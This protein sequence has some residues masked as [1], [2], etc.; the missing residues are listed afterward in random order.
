VKLWHAPARPLPVAVR[1]VAGE[2][3]PSYA[4]RLAAANDLT[5][6]AVLRALGHPRT[7]IGKHLLICDARINEH[8]AAR[9]EAYTGI[10]RERLAR[11]LPAMTRQMH[12]GDTLPPD[13]PT[14]CFIRAQ[15]RP[16]CRKCEL[17]ATG[18]DR[19]A[20]LALPGW[21]PLVCHRHRRWL[22]PADDT[23][24]HDLSAA[25]GILAAGRRL[26]GL[27][28]RSG[29]RR[30]AWREFRTAWNITRDWPG[31]ALQRMPVLAERWHDRAAALGTSTFVTT[32][33]GNRASWIV[34]FPEAVA[35][36][37]ILTDLNLR[38]YIALEY[39]DR[40]L[41]RRISASIGEQR[42]QAWA[43]HNAP[44]RK[45]VTIHRYKFEQLRIGAWRMPLPPPERF[46]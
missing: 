10:P 46:K 32:P 38:R 29:D 25:P 8:A 12:P 37:A 14:L 20:A 43:Y 3:L 23:T 5:P 28:A 26:A 44:V 4:R 19:P 41:Y 30:W 6:Y 18:A 2:T 31:P 7:T 45:W 27:L 40:P 15:T 11:A 22:G 35:L 21:T 39:D 24:Q 9:L 16:P 36:T 34:A 1:P 42:Y 33:A 17:A 13:R